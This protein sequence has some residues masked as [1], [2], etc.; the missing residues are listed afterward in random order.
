MYP[1]LK[2][3]DGEFVKIVGENLINA[4]KLDKKLNPSVNSHMMNCQFINLKKNDLTKL[5]QVAENSKEIGNPEEDWSNKQI[6]QKRVLIYN[7]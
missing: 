3:Q 1:N 4:L 6:M 7:K 5:K 2:I